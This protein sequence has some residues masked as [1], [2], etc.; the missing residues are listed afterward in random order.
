MI[1][2]YRVLLKRRVDWRI[3]LVFGGLCLAGCGGDDGL[4]KR[5]PVSGKVTFMG[6][7]L[8][9][10]TITFTPAEGDAGIRPASG[11]IVDGGYQL[12]TQTDRDGAMPGKYKVSIVSKN[13]DEST[14]KTSEGNAVRRDRMAKI[15]AKTKNLVPPIYNVPE[16]SGLTSTVPGGP[17]DFDLK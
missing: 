5:V 1:I 3:M 17:Y 15:V 6:A 16:T 10:G 14:G 9:R 2:Q 13:F 8:A 4:T 12:T 11:S 7:P